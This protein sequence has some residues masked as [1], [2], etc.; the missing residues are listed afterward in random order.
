VIS[1]E[2]PQ[3]DAWRELI[4]V[5]SRQGKIRD[6]LRAILRDRSVAGYHDDLGA[7]LA[8]PG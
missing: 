2:D 8:P 5:A 6:L 3:I 4:D 1:I 7:L